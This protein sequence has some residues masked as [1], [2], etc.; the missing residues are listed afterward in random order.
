VST[1][2]LLIRS[3]RHY[4]M[5]HLGVALA[6][7]VGTAVVVAALVAGASFEASLE[8]FANERI[9]GVSHA[10]RGVRGPFQPALAGRLSEALGRPATPLV[11]LDASAATTDDARRLGG[12]R[13]A[14]IDESFA[15][16]TG[17]TDLTPP[18]SGEV[19]V[20]RVLADSL[21]LAV[22]DSLVLRVA[23]TDGPL[24]GTPLA[25]QSV[26]VSPLVL[27]IAG[28][29][30]ASNG[31]SFDL[32]ANQQATPL[33]YVSQSFLAKRLPQGGGA[34]WVLVAGGEELDSSEIESVARQQ[35][36]PE[37][38]GLRLEKLPGGE[39]SLASPQVFLPDELV[40]AL[41]KGGFE[42]MEA[43]A[44]LATELK[45]G[46][47]TIPYSMIAGLAGPPRR[48]PE[49]AGLGGSDVLLNQ[50]TADKLEAGLGDRL[51]MTFYEYLPG[52][53]Q[54]TGNAAFT[55]TGIL[56]MSGLGADRALLPPFPGLHDAETCDS[57]DAG[58]ELDLSLIGPD[59]EA[60]WKQY[61][62]APKAIIALTGAKRYWATRAGSLTGLRLAGD[63]SRE[64]LVAA[65]ANGLAPE[66]TGIA[67]DPVAA[68][69]RLAV[70]QAMDMSGLMLGFGF[71]LIVAALLLA[72]AGTTLAVRARS[73]E[74]GTLAALG[75]A[76]GK[77]LRLRLSEM[78][79]VA[80]CSALPGI[81]L[82]LGLAWWM[83]EIIGS[84]WS[85]PGESSA[86][87]VTFPVARILVGALAGTL[88][89]LLLT[90]GI[91][92]R[93]SRGTAIAALSD[94]PPVGRSGFR[95]RLFFWAVV[96]VLLSGTA[97]AS[98]PLMEQQ[99]VPRAIAFFGAG[100]IL[101]LGIL[102]AVNAL[103]SGLREG[104][105]VGGSFGWWSLLVR[106]LTFQRT[107]TMGAVALLA[108]A[109]FMVLGAEAHRLAVPEVTER[110]SGTGGFAL[111]AETS[112]P[113]FRA[114][115]DEEGAI[116]SLGESESL[117]AMRMRPGDEASCRNLNRPQNPRVLG[118]SS[119]QLGGLNAFQFAET[120]NGLPSSWEVLSERLPDG[121]IAAVADLNT[122]V[123]SLGA[124][125][126]DVIE[127]ADDHGEPQ[128]LRLVGALAN[129][130]LQG[131]LII[132]EWP[133]K[134][135]FPTAVGYRLFLL[136][137]AADGTG[138]R[139][140]K[141]AARY[142]DFGWVAEPTAVRLAQFMAVQNTYLSAF[143]LMGMLALIL[144]SLGFGIIMLRN[145]W[146]RRRDLALLAG[147]GVSPR[148][149][150]RWLVAEHLVMLAT[151]FICGVV[152]SAVALAPV[153]RQGAGSVAWS[154]LLLTMTSALVAGIIATLVAAR[155]G[156]KDSVMTAL[157]RD[158]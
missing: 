56:P 99:S 23:K 22:G 27:R 155:W 89:G 26:G 58:V 52:G 153:L 54:A 59:D 75:W 131:A 14:G 121:E 12:V 148:R 41:R 125:V 96:S 24:P 9:G 5:R 21:E 13:L 141:L 111:L 85:A 2:K 65:L 18:E 74:V 86:L 40:P 140:D 34:N 92:L 16:T 94:R 124:K 147:V 49:L 91:L 87:V 31:G 120:W 149:A 38:L 103:L 73:R 53:R 36:H 3:L 150:R 76:P 69:A 66:V 63:V 37:D 57:W 127:I 10:V 8:R 152:P 139:D 100:G 17:W 129:S 28:V 136:D 104:R 42:P 60:Y 142:R 115:P 25:R 101:L 84:I 6:L 46:E 43:L 20:N 1:W 123:W 151:S 112:V 80:I 67:V 145:T 122:I 97:V 47:R 39:W 79:V 61:R 98:I 106:N 19:L 95:G 30:A 154:G 114:G 11:L 116:P 138:A 50:W 70:D 118:V 51:E 109:L 35:L 33:A 90:A 55:V 64:K 32:F 83:V 68:Q 126:G 4:A 77:I 45:V 44:Y 102:A 62:G 105:D 158:N 15:T 88:L 29:V 137:G 133:F 7:A 146:E 119:R 110:S 71:F 135:L 130:V 82:G 108:M 117:I 132:G 128:R 48:Y 81:L 156:R 113:L 72:G 157:R 78:S 143:Q 107:R 134:R 93:Q 144:G